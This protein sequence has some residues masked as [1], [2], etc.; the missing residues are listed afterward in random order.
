MWQSREKN[1][2]KVNWYRAQVAVDLQAGSQA[3]QLGGQI[4]GPESSGVRTGTPAPPDP[5]APVSAWHTF[6]D[7]SL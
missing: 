6:R 7:G 2:I 5:T 4:A 3:N 1:Y